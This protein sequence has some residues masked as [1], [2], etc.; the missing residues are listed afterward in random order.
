M[1]EEWVELKGGVRTSK[2]VEAQK[3]AARRQE[4]EVGSR[5]TFGSV[6]DDDDGGMGRSKERRDGW[7]GC[8]EV[9]RRRRRRQMLLTAHMDD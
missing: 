1:G 3:P 8:R 2:E 9:R 5:K 7:R 4:S 6:D